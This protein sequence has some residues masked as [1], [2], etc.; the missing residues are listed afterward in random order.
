MTLRDCL[1][2]RL[3]S[4]SLIFLDQHVSAHDAKTSFVRIELHAQP[5]FPGRII[6]A[7]AD[8]RM[9]VV[10]GDGYQLASPSKHG[11]VPAIQV[12]GR[13]RKEIREHQISVTTIGPE[14]IKED[15]CGV[16]LTR[17]CEEIVDLDSVD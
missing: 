10:A 9:R 14:S 3:L 8:V 12:R 6:D 11:L 15:H 17:V 7:Q 2:Q 13:T 5:L 4:Q 1:K 16:V